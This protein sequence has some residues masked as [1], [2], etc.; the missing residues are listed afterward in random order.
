MPNGVALQIGR[1]P[2]ENLTYWPELHSMS[3]KRLK[4]RINDTHD[5]RSEELLAYLLRRYLA[6]NRPTGP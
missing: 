2:T 4:G 3:C 6:T 1:T 5:K